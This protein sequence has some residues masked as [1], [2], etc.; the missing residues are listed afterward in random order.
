MNKRIHIIIIL[1]ISV[2]I[3][4]TIFSTSTMAQETPEDFQSVNVDL[5]EDGSAEWTI[6]LRNEFND[7]GDRESFES[8]QDEFNTNQETFEENNRERFESIINVAES[9]TDR[10][11]NLEDF[12][13]S[14]EIEDSGTN[15]FGLTKI[16]FTWVGFS[17]VDNNQVNVGDVFH[18]GYTIGSQERLVLYW[19]KQELSLQSE[20]FSVQPAQRTDN[21]ISWTGPASFG[22][23]EPSLIFNSYDGASETSSDDQIPIQLIGGVALLTLLIVAL[24]GYYFK[25]SNDGK[26]SESSQEESDPDDEEDTESSDELKTDREKVVEYIENNGGRV[27]QNR[28]K[29]KFDWSD[30]KI[31]RLT[32]E[33]EEDEIIEKLRIGRENVLE[34]DE[35]G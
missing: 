16:Q 15:E 18:N 22:D 34:L 4:T 3:G 6:E 2:L 35:E 28:I 5:K 14:A 27:K 29:E 7:D 1:L 13:M 33:L 21:S 25:K 17:E 31:S 9:E 26:L 30:S 19:D 32:N 23:D 20:S 12:R 24:V 11:M 8:W 10:S